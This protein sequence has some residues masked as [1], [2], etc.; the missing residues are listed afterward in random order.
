MLT[1]NRASKRTYGAE[2]VPF[3]GLSASGQFVLA[4]IDAVSTVI[5]TNETNNEIAFGP[6]LS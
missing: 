3:L 1:R 2:A 6:V 5:E 4:V